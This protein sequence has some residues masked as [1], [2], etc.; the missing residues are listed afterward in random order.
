M[1]VSNLSD[2]NQDKVLDFFKVEVQN[3][4]VQMPLISA[5]GN[6]GILI[7][8]RFETKTLETDIRSPEP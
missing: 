1:R 6:K 2:T 3:L 7:I 8:S 5:L 4:Q